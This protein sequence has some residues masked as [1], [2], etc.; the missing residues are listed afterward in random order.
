MQKN[1]EYL[2]FL[3]YIPTTKSYKAVNTRS[4]FDLQAE[5]GTSVEKLTSTSTF[6]DYRKEFKN[7][8]VFIA[9]V[10]NAVNLSCSNISK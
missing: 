10:K 7:R 4:S 3:S 5:G 1:K 2:L 6:L 8:D 9:E